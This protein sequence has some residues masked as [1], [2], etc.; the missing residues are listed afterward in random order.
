MSGFFLMIFAQGA[1]EGEA[2][3]MPGIPERR[4]QGFMMRENPI[5][6]Q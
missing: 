1:I 4:L 2:E 3:C 6:I 5:F